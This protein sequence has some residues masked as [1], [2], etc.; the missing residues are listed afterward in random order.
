MQASKA[1][2]TVDSGGAWISFQVPSVQEA[3]EQCD[4]MIPGKLY[5]LE[6]KEYSK[7]RSLSAN[8]LLWKVIGEMAKELAKTNPKITPDEIYRKY[9]RDSANNYV[10]EVWEDQLESLI[11][12]WEATGI[13]WIGEPTEPAEM[14]DGFTK[15]TVRLWYGSSSYDSREMAG[16]IDAVLQDAHAMGLA[17]DNVT[18][19]MEAYPDGQ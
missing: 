5:D 7:K 2:W 9:I 4:K 14:V 10:A 8:S 13:G 17:S 18:A 3:R 19:L 16:L 11:R 1:K 12:T 6:I 15:W